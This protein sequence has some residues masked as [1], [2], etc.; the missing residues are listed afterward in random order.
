MK[1]LNKEL[2]IITCVL[3]SLLMFILTG[4]YLHHQKENRLNTTVNVIC[5]GVRMELNA[6]EFKKHKENL[7]DEIITISQPVEDLLINS[8][9][10][11][12]EDTKEELIYLGEFLITGYCDCPICQEEWVGTTAIGVAPTEEWTIAVDPDVIP[13]GSYVLIDGHRYCAEDVGGAINDNHIDMFMGSHEDC[14]QDICNGYKD[15]YLEVVE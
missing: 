3:L 8:E 2:T 9:E 14:Y 1:K 13:L 15:V 10:V 12:K 11:V 4:S 7:L 6:E 5:N